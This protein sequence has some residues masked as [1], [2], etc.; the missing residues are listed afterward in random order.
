MSD[1]FSHSREDPTLSGVTSPVSSGVTYN[2]EIRLFGPM[3]VRVGGRPLPH[4]RSRKGLWLLA[5]LALRAGR[6]VDRDYLVGMLWPDAPDRDGRRSL[7]Q[8]LYDLRLALGPEAE[9]LTGESS[10]TLR[11]DLAGDTWVDVLVFDRATAG[12]RTGQDP[13]ELENAVS[14]YHA[15]LLEECAEEW[16][17]EERARREQQYV[18]AL[19]ALAA[20]AT[21]YSGYTAAAGYLRRAV[22]VAPLREDLLRHLMTALAADGSVSAALLAYREFRTR[23]WQ[24]MATEPDAE[25]TALYQRLRQEIRHTAQGKTIAPVAPPSLGSDS[26]RS[27]LPQSRTTLIGREDDQQEVITRLTQNRLVTLTGTGGVGKTRLALRVTEVMTD[28]FEA[29]ARFVDLA[30]LTVPESVPETV[31]QAL[32]LLQDRNAATQSPLDTLCQALRSRRLLL[33]LD[34]CEHLLDACAVLVDTLLTVC[35]GLRI[36]ATSR[37]PLGLRGESVYRV[38]SLEQPPPSATVPEILHT[39]AARLFV[40]RARDADSTFQVTPGNISALVRVCRRL[41][42]IPLAIEL[43]AARVRVLPLEEIDTRLGDTFRLL[44]GGDRA[45]LPRQQ[46]LRGALDW[47]WSLLSEPERTLLAALCVFAGG[48]TLD[49]AENVCAGGAISREDVLDL[50]TALVDKSLVNVEKDESAGTSRYS[51]LETVRQ[52]GAERLIAD[53]A[54]SESIRKRHQRYYATLVTAPAPSAE[55]RPGNR[56]R[57]LLAEQ[58]NLRLALRWR[59]QDAT[60]R[61]ENAL[62]ILNLAVSMGDFWI[63]NSNLREAEEQLR[64]ALDYATQVIGEDPSEGDASTTYTTLRARTLKALSVI[65]RDRGDYPEAQ[66]LFEQALALYQRLGD[67]KNAAD[68]LREIGM[69]VRLQSEFARAQSLL[70]Q[71]HA[72]YRE[73]DDR[74]NIA[75]SLMA[76]GVVA[77]EQADIDRSTARFEEAL[78]VLREIGDQ[79]ATAIALSNLS[80]NS[81]E[82]KDYVTAC[83]LLDEALEIHQAM[84]NQKSV[85][86][87]LLNRG[88]CESDLGDQSAARRSTEDA[89]AIF[90]ASGMKLGVANALVSLGSVQCQLGETLPARDAL[91]EAITLYRELGDTVKIAST[92]HNIAGLEA[93]EGHWEEVL[94]TLG[95]AEA[96]R[97]SVDT[98]IRPSQRT[99]EAGFIARARAALPPD[100]ADAAWADGRSMDVEEVFHWVLGSRTKDRSPI[101]PEKVR[102]SGDSHTI[103]Q[104]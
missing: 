39:A 54:D 62:C 72:I 33:L 61:S 63:E 92:L 85:A 38:P 56:M 35:P 79:R 103:S 31:R 20:T 91:R 26:A 57:L 19:E 43:A 102:E 16:V 96:V 1:V 14:L 104:S 13:T 97:Q 4:L 73:L 42:G 32:G 68:T 48:C 69:L 74:H 93:A 70:E 76:L 51:L 55:A 44:T 65:A 28:E 50:L 22:E 81:R 37:Q 59:G 99:E 83:R 87:A 88:N 60:D 41:D 52:Y 17:V 75:L 8:S 23:L 24:D 64:G 67:R 2:L 40:D 6:D 84:G 71:A 10:R 98:P 29:G 80:I 21:L 34:N 101:P 27:S 82:R 94:R 86:V 49:A 53:V 18:A 58:E 47:S 12:R 46:T 7:R 77:G 95:A 100:D 78:P 25:T 11:L 3:E 66:A 89:L 90:R 45:A 9:R 5:L 30:P 15:P 36:L